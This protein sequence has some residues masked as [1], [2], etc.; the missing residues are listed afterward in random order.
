MNIT[1][2]R[3][4]TVNITDETSKYITQQYLRQL[5]G[6]EERG[7]VD[8]KAHPPMVIADM[9]DVGTHKTEY[10]RRGTRLA[11]EEDLIFWAALEALKHTVP[12]SS[13]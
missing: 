1:G 13:K 10:E 6:I 4:T 2:T 8:T 12:G 7:W 3:Q 9:V 11:T 5:I